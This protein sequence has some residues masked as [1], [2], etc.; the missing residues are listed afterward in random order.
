MAL[1]IFMAVS[2]PVYR[3]QVRRDLEEELIFRGQEHVRA[4]QKY[5]RRFGIYP[6]T[7]EALIETNGLRFLRRQYTDPIT[8]DRFRLLTINP[9]G[10][11]NGSTLYQ[12][13]VGNTPLL[14]GETPRMFGQS[15]FGQMGPASQESVRDVGP[16]HT[17]DAST[18]QGIFE[19][20]PLAGG[21]QP[22]G[23]STVGSFKQQQASVGGQQQ[24]TTSFGIV[25]VASENKDLSVKTYNNRKKYNEWEFIAMPGFG[26]VP[27]ATT[28]VQAPGVVLGQSNNQFQQNQSSPFTSTPPNSFQ[29]SPTQPQLPADTLKSSPTYNPTQ[30][31]PLG[32]GGPG[33]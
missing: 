12:Q 16:Q 23:L 32:P 9:D 31:R 17:S 15:G 30:A 33:T 3:M 21:G 24:T 2:L 27:A 4:I 20:R 28:G 10:S 26:T 8:G 13:R 25:G 5:K 1:S 14:Q 19:T 18:S 7:M 6:P 22:E 11:I 29:R